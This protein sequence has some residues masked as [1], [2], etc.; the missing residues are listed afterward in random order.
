MT[1][2][3]ATHCGVKPASEG[4]LFKQRS[5]GI[6]RVHIGVVA[7]VTAIT[8]VG[9]A[10]GPLWAQTPAKV[11]PSGLPLPRYVS[12]KSDRVNLRKGP[13][14]DYPTAWVYRRAGLPVEVVEEYESWRKVRDAEGTTGWILSALLSGRRTALVLPWELKRE[15]ARPQVALRT[16]GSDRAQAVAMIE[17]GVI[18]D[19]QSCDGDWCYVTIQSFRGYLEQKQLWGVY[20]NEQLK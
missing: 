17:A 14:T 13:G 9:A 5:G 10:A 8:L 18:A 19:V 3:S 1:I 11:G 7:F 16:S 15:A 4:A 20:A 6:W 2:R 12:L